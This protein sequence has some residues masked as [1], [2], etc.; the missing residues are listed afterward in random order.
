MH[1][2]LMGDPCPAISLNW[3]I[4]QFDGTIAAPTEAL[5]LGTVTKC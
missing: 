2:D 5:A 1:Y 4:H 3:T